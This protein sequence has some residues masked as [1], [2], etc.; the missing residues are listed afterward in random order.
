MLKNLV[1]KWLPV[2]ALTMSAF[3]VQAQEQPVKMMVGFAPGSS[4]DIILRILAEELRPILGRTVLVENR[5]GAGGRLAAQAL[6]TATG[7]SNTYLLAPDSWAVFPTLLYTEEQLRYSI[8]KD[9][10]PVARIVSYPLA[11]FTSDKMGVNTL[12]EYL[13]KAKK[14]PSLGMYGS[15]GSGSIT[16]FL[17]IVMSKEFGVPMNV[18][19]FK[20]GSEVKTNLIGNQVPVAVMTAGDGVADNNPRVKPLGLFVSERWSLAPNIPTMKEQGYNITQGAAFS[21]VWTTNKTPEA[22]RKKMEQAIQTVLTK[23]EVQARLTKL[24]VQADFAKGEDLGKQV[25]DL[26]AYWG[27]IVKESGFKPQ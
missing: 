18:V 20:G 12:A 10:A 21:G 9:F 26:W 25:Q 6:K 2:A 27:P 17:G 8:Q 3:A 4:G 13:E 24:F 14:D 7:D 23:P 11:L 19:P 5:P 1:S 16:E 15:S 22:E